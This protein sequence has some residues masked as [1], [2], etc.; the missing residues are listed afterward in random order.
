MLSEYHLLSA[1]TL[2][3]FN[4]FLLSAYA[5]RIISIKN[6]NAL[7]LR[8]ELKLTRKLQENRLLQPTGDAIATGGARI[9]GELVAIGEAAV[10]S[11]QTK[12]DCG[13]I[14]SRDGLCGI[15]ALLAGSLASSNLLLF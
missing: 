11:V 10:Q 3:G 2:S 9:V 14:P 13:I 5:S 12:L 1:Y 8:A 7:T 15:A 4:S 6:F